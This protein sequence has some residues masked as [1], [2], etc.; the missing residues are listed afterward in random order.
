[1]RGHTSKFAIATA[2]GLGIGFLLLP[3]ISPAGDARHSGRAF[4][5]AQ[6]LLDP[7]VSVITIA[8]TNRGWEFWYGPR[9][10]ELMEDGDE[11]KHGITVQRAG[12]S[13]PITYTMVNSGLLEANVNDIFFDEDTELFWIA[14]ATKG[15]AVVDV[16]ASSWTYVH[17][18]HGLPSNITYAITK[19]DGAIWV[20][21]QRG[22]ARELPDGTFRGYGRDGGLPG[23]RIRSMFSNADDVLW[24]AIIEGGAVL[25]DPASAQ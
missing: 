9:F 22:V 7:V 20:G 11:R 10:E 4:R 17:M 19:I 21:T 14:F 8:E 13:R 1:M 6:G 23:E 15:L 24:S 25:L 12:L 18:E 3:A 16:D 5:P 2:A